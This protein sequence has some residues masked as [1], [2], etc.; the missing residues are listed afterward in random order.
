MSELRIITGG[1]GAGKERECIRQICEVHEKN[2]EAKCIMLV[3]E[4]YS[5][6][7]EKSFIDAFSGTGLNNIEVKTF[8]KL[9]VDTLSEK[10]YMTPAGKHTLLSRA[11]GEFSKMVRPD[12]EKTGEDGI[13]YI[14]EGLC[15]SL[16]K[17][18]FLDVLASMISE[19]KRYEITPEEL[20]GMACHTGENEALSQKL[21]V[22]SNIYAIYTRLFLATGY[23]DADDTYDELALAIENGNDFDGV[24]LWID[25]FDELLPQQM[26]VIRALY[27]KVKRMTVSVCYPAIESEQ[28]LYTQTKHTLDK[29]S[30][31][32]QN[33]RVYDCGRHL[34]NIKNADLLFF[35]DKFLSYEKYTDSPQ[36][37]TLF[38]SGSAYGEVKFA[39]N[40]ILKLVFD[41][42][43]RFRDICVVC[44]DE[45]AYSH[46]IE[47]VFDE[48]KIPYFT[49]SSMLFSEHPAAGQVLSLF[50]MFENRF[51]FESVL[52]YLRSGYIYVK[53]ENGTVNLQKLCI[54]GADIDELE[55]YAL[56]YGIRGEKKWLD[57]K[58]EGEKSFVDSA[59][60]GEAQETNIEG[61]EELRALIAAPIKRYR[62][63]TR[64]K[65]SAKQ[66]AKALFELLEDIHMY[67][68][69]NADISALCKNPDNEKNIT[70]A[71]TLEKL[72]NLLMQMLEQLVGALDGEEISRNEFHKY[73][74]IALEQCEIRMIP[75]GIDRVYVGSAERISA[76]SI[77]AMFMLGANDGCYPSQIKTEGFLS[78]AD[79]REINSAF[80][81][82]VAPDTSVNMEKR[83]YSVWSVIASVR[84][85][86]WITYSR[87][88]SGGNEQT[89]ARLFSNTA[90]RFPKLKVLCE[91]DIGT[92][93][94]TPKS[95]L[96]EMLINKSS[97]NPKNDKIWDVVYDCLKEEKYGLGEIS[98]LWKSAKSYTQTAEHISP[99][100]ARLLY[101]DNVKYSASRLNVYAGCPFKYF[102]NYGLGLRKR[103]E[104]EI[105]ASDIGTYAHSVIEQFCRAVE[106]D[107]KTP[108]EKLEMW[109]SLSEDGARDKIIDE[110]IDKTIENI[111]ADDI[112]KRE[113]IKSIMNRTGSVIKK[114]AKTVHNSLKNGKYTIAAEENELAAKISDEITVMGRVDRIDEYTDDGDTKHIRII[115]YKTG[116]TAFD[117][118]HIYYGLDMQL[119]IYAILARDYFKEK[120]NEECSVSGMYY[121]FVK[122]SKTIRTA[123]QSES[124]VREDIRK[125]GLLDGVTFVDSA[126]EFDSLA[127]V[128]E[129]YKTQ[130]QV[131]K[132]CYTQTGNISPKQNPLIRDL[133]DAEAL[134]SFAEN[135]IKSMDDRIRNEGDIKINPARDTKYNACDYCEYSGICAMD[136]EI[137]CREMPRTKKKEEVWD[138]IRKNE[139][140]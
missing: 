92:V 116:N 134:M 82:S 137:Q 90:V 7:M 6:E 69:I 34:K 112:Y 10:K 114:A 106:K 30:E 35:T 54:K 21:T 138:K 108:A 19:M 13:I 77:R 23:V 5:Y 91:N 55:N 18:G 120:R 24:Y 128:D 65:K 26:R 104:F 12:T 60:G 126:R 135:R 136:G 2:P 53:N 109:K 62:R 115:D 22:I 28:A 3:N 56:K 118:E 96:H 39:A 4:H 86:L 99:K 72:W 121:N 98:D 67:E 127:D 85:K 117:I 66:H 61:I 43:Y 97:A 123:N 27:N 9:A 83:R 111:D 80:T 89:P 75:S 47:T 64:A 44:G 11:V 81:K 58:W 78:D 107:A 50:K 41:E 1:I 57:T 119:V 130:S 79:R 45:A 103:D 51:D 102:M 94:S 31:L 36:N 87:V 88:D 84:E 140:E 14:N 139:E 129:N 71:R 16:G 93:I 68:G 131:I 59:L 17:Q 37:I 110:I 20:Y 29:I 70:E 33:A 25:K 8:R 95:A 101:G 113:H 122:S 15:S 63:K 132:I 48:Y 105:A 76:V 124:S 49:D 133:K 52:E 46:L 125:E 38:K 42:G 32:D 100:L 73:L 74:K 40:E